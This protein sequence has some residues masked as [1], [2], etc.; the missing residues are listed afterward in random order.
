[1]EKGLIPVNDR[2]ASVVADVDMSEGAR[3]TVLRRRFKLTLADVA[4]ATSI[5]EHKLSEMERG[6]R[7]VDDKVLTFMN[8]HKK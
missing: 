2:V 7:T 1:M 6:I 5:H 3:I 8:D 4:A